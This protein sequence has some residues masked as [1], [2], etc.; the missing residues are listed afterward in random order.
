MSSKPLA[1]L[2]ITL[3]DACSSSWIFQDQCF[4]LL[5]LFFFFFHVCFNYGVYACC[6]ILKFLFSKWFSIL[7][8]LNKGFDCAVLV[9]IPRS[10]YRKLF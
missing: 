7:K 10:F 6:F 1:I 8:R 9:G 5:L 4:S 2:M 3:N